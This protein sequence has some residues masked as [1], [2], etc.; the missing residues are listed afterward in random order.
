MVKYTT[1]SVSMLPVYITYQFTLATSQ[2][3]LPVK[4]LP[5]QYSTKIHLK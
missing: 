1:L 3:F 4:L 2:T 5:I